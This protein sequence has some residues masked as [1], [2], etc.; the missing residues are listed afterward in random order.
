MPKAPSPSSV[1]TLSDLSADLRRRD[2]DLV[3]DSE[4]LLD[5]VTGEASPVDEIHPEALDLLA[6]AFDDGALE[7]LVQHGFDPSQ[8]RAVVPPDVVDQTLV[9]HHR[10]RVQDAVHAEMAVDDDSQPGRPANKFNS[11]I[12][13]IWNSLQR[14]MRPCA[15]R[16]PPTSY[17]PPR[18]CDALPERP[19]SNQS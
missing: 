3:L 19:T 7:L 16:C 6:P 17:G 4:D 11:G 9:E 1:Q 18:A 14:A 5:L 13:R 10:P 15:Q 8:Q 12:L 2:R